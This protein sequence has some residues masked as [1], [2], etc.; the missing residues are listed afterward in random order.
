MVA[1]AD[2]LA[3]GLNEE[4]EDENW[5]GHPV[6]RVSTDQLEDIRKKL[7]DEE[8]YVNDVIGI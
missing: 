2:F 1:F 3:H 6:F 7:A 8:K 4:Q 5:F